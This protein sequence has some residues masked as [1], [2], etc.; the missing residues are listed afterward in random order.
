VGDDADKPDPST[1]ADGRARVRWREREAAP[2]D[3][4][5]LVD[6]AELPP[7]L[8]RVLVA[9][10]VK[11]AEAAAS[12][13]APKLSSLP[14]PSRLQGIDEAV[15]RVRRALHKGEKIGIF[16]DY[17]V[18]GVTST[19]VLW[20]FLEAAGG[21]VCATLPDRLTEGYG[22]SRA[23]V[24][25]LADA[26]AGLIV[27]V[28]CG[29]T[30]HEEVAYCAER[31]I[32]VVVIDHHT[33]P[34]ELPRAVAVIN[35]HRGD[36][37]A[38]A[39]H[40][41]AVGVTF[42]LCLALRRRLRDEGWFSDARPEP[43]LR[44]ALDL[45]ALG[46]VADVVPLVD[47]NRVFVTW[48]LKTIARRGR[49]G[50]RALLE[51]AAVDARRAT[52]ST[53]GFQVGPRINAAGRLGDAMKAVRLFRS[54]HE[55]EARSLAEGLDRENVSRR[56][57]ERRIV[58]E[59]IAEVDGSAEHREA[60]VLVVGREEWHP[61]VVGIVASRLVE[62]YG[63][64]AVVVGEAGRGSG[65]SVPKYH[66]F[67]GLRAVEDTLDGFGGHAHAAGV[68]VTEGGLQRFRDALCA[69]AAEVLRPEDLER[70]QLYDGDLDVDA[71]DLQLCETLARAAPFGRANPEPV[72][73]VPDVSPRGLRELK[74]GH[75]KANVHPRRNVEAILF[76][77]GERMG[78]FVGGL[79]VLG[80]PEINEWR[81]DRT[82]QLRL[83]DFRKAEPT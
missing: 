41:C 77:Q 61:G 5:A 46:T 48:G 19:T 25:R 53:L 7:P 8:A 23:G 33:V 81:G 26:G 49:L 37:D 65:R 30:A 82:V 58:E 21:E 27:T 17:D 68:R 36:D 6:G 60:R 70:L 14:D 64:P 78:E 22:L 72:F 34:V 1:P 31:G 83:R 29:V 50:M 3:V 28:D 44:H 38:G 10:G 56:D 66:L 11:D 35:P 43:D 9:R 40:L 4:R 57:L 45:V 67:D 18:D 54:P 20:D 15:D 13:L 39:E 2:E 76:G 59:A 42:N 52:A 69:Q 16:G 80:V 79:D 71:V 12:Y 73:R 62:R 24:D 51:V 47:D 63:K 32:D 75:F 74:G 55:Q